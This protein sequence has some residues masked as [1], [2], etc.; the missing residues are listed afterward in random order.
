MICNG[1]VPQQNDKHALDNWE[2][3]GGFVPQRINKD[4]GKKEEDNKKP[5]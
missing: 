2:N 5:H 1:P 3:E 4:V